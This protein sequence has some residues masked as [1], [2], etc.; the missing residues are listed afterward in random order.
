[1]YCVKNIADDIFY[2]GA[3]DRRLELFENVFP[4]PRGVS[5]NSYLILDNK[6]ALVDTVDRSVEPRFFENVDYA[7]AGR[8]LD[9]LIIN[10]M[11]PDHAATVADTLRRYPGVRLI[12]NKKIAA[13]LGQFFDSDIASQAQL[14]AEGDTISLGTHTLTFIMAPM[15]HWPEVM[16]TYD[17]TSKT[18][19]SADAFGTF[20]ALSGGIFADEYDFA[21]EWLSDARSYYANIVGKYGQQVQ[22]LLKKASTVEIETLCPLHGPVWRKNIGWFVEKYQ[23]WSSYTPE[24]KAVVVAYAS[25]YGNT[26]NAADI[27]ACRLADDGVQNIAMYD[28]SR[29]H[30][31]V[32]VAEA[33]RAS[34]LVFASTTYNAGIF[35][36]M[37]TALDD[38]AAHNLQKRKIALIENGSWAPT[39]G[40]LMRA[41]LEPLRDITFIGDTVT[42]R[43]SVKNAQREQLCALADEIAGDIKAS[44]NK[45]APADDK[46]VDPNAMFKLS[47]GLFVLAARDGDKDNA[48]IINT[49]S[50]ITDIPKRVSIT[51]NKANLTHDMIAKTGRF[52]I[53]VL[54]E[55]VPF[56]V[57]ENFGFRSG[58]DEDKF[59]GCECVSRDASGIRYVHKYTNAYISGK[60]AESIDCGT[61]TVFIA[62]VT[63]A[64]ILSDAPSVTYA[65]YFANIK[66]KPAPT[67]TP[68]RGFVC[69]ICGYFYE[70]ETLPPDFIC[71]LCKHGAEDFEPV[72]F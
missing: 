51:V 31:S 34:H 3:S 28:V 69:K 26:E 8:Q 67:D 24:E 57:F 52:T 15:V 41:I 70:G 46:S 40:S 49:V 17:I 56:K 16:V 36:N 54:T 64:K 9:Y 25:V 10:H 47:Y 2:V 68:K 39:S 13:M 29:T 38:I 63:E 62:D 5:Y 55:E 32:I 45:T 20:G 14:V 61:H 30:P 6:T 1:M 71:P 65:Y 66:P 19:F 22:A 72:G 4:I 37:Q 11:E 58:R 33:F 7:L 48:C 18:L 44:E 42:V 43:S 35:I 12:C 27:L 23:R 21:G 60:V 50:Q 53:S 59:A